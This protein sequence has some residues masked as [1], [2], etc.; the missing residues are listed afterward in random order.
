M[1]ARVYT[2]AHTARDKQR[3]CIASAV[4]KIFPAVAPF[5]SPTATCYSSIPEDPAIERRIRQEVKSESYFPGRFFLVSFL[6]SPPRR[7]A[8]A[9]LY[10]SPLSFLF[11]ACLAYIPPY[12]S[13]CPIREKTESRVKTVR[14]RRAN[15]RVD[16]LRKYSVTVSTD[17]A[18]SPETR[19]LPIR[20]YDGFLYF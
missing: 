13:T 20:K 14:C 10:L 5:S 18:V 2:R 11:P 1:C 12:S 17:M 15:P 16:G 4:R 7:A 6:L 3:Q 9:I 19:P 8:W